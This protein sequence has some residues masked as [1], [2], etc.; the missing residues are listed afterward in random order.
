MWAAQLKLLEG[1]SFTSRPLNLTKNLLK[2]RNPNFWCLPA[3]TPGSVHLVSSTSN[4]DKP[5]WLAT[6]L[7]WSRDLTSLGTRE[8]VRSLNMR[9]QLLGD[10][11][12][13]WIKIGLPAKAK[14]EAELPDAKD[15]EKYA[16]CEREA[17][18][19]SLVNLL[20]YPY[21]QDRVAKGT[22]KL[23]GGHYDFVNGKFELW[24]V[25]LGIKPLLHI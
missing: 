17:V 9:S 14:V 2:A 12:H 24:G 10:F 23:M 5:S 15:E 18:N 1:G 4:Q 13:D 20:T 7:T 16:R 22:L 3:L 11:I 19:L 6:S 8:L 21:V 25:D